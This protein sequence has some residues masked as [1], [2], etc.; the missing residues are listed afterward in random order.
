MDNFPECRLRDTD[1]YLFI[2]LLLHLNL[3]ASL[4]GCGWVMVE[5]PYLLNYLYKKNLLSSHEELRFQSIFHPAAE[6]RIFNDMSAF[7]KPR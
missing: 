6:G 1:F 5:D 2:F 7:N 4:L 3:R